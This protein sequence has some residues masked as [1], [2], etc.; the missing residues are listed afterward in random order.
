VVNF[1]SYSLP[2]G[3]LPAT[4]SSIPWIRGRVDSVQPLGPAIRMTRIM[5]VF[6]VWPSVSHPWDV[7]T[8]CC[9]SPHLLK[10]TFS[11][12]KCLPANLYSYT[13]R[14]IVS[15]LKFSCVTLKIKF[16]GETRKFCIRIVWINSY[17]SFILVGCILLRYA[18]VY[19]SDI[20]PRDI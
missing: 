6:E 17:R 8:F 13:V 7:E 12:K 9:P 18:H 4:R 11:R 3:K 16:Y 15:S 19:F 5:L 14:L 20:Y 10:R 1:G 2:Q